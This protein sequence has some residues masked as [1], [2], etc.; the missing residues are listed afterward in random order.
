MKRPIVI[1]IALVIGLAAFW[2]YFSLQPPADIEPMG[3]DENTTAQW[4]T[5]AIG[6]VSLLTAVTGLI[7]KI[8]ELRAARQGS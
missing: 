4:I 7:Q 2:Y 6:I 3:D 1:V 5:L 8:V